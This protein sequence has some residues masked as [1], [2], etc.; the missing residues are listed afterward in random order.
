LNYQHVVAGTEAAAAAN[1][2]L[3]PLSAARSFSLVPG[4]GSSVSGVVGGGGGFSRVDTVQRASPLKLLDFRAE[5]S[6]IPD[7]ASIQRVDA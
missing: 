5:T 1:Q 4:I 3:L 2:S 7:D 6:S